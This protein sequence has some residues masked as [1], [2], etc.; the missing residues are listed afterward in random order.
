MSITI[1]QVSVTSTSSIMHIM[2]N[3]YVTV[4]GIYSVYMHSHL[5][6]TLTHYQALRI[7]NN[8]IGT[9]SIIVI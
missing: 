6:H 8:L 3:H 7:K 5:Y 9:S 1:N 2:A 4:D